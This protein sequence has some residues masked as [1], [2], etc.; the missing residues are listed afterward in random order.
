MAP[1]EGLAAAGP[2][3]PLPADGRRGARDRDA[4][5]RAGAARSPPPASS[6][7]V[8]VVVGT[9]GKA[10]GSYGAYV[11]ADAEMVEYLLNTA[12]SFIFS[13]A[14]PPPSVAAAQAGAGAARS[15]AGD[16]R[17]ARRQRRRPARGAGRRG[18]RRSGARRA[19]SSRSRSATPTQAMRALR[20]AARAR[21][22][23]PG[24]PA[25][26]RPRGHL[27]AALHGDGDPRPE[28]ELQRAARALG[29]ADARASAS[30]APRAGRSPRRLTGA[31]MRGVFVTG[32][33]TEVG[34][35]VVAAAI[36]R[37]LAAAGRAGR[38]L[39]A[40]RHRPRRPGRGRPRAAAPGRRARGRATR[41]SP[42]TAT[43]RR[44][45]PTSAAA[46]AGEEIDPARLRA[47]AAQAAAA[48]PT[49]SSARGSAACSCRS[50]RRLPG[51]RPRRRPRAAAGRSPPRPGSGRSTTRC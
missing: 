15:R 35:T 30:A 22:L 13:T 7:E 43:G 32:T 26:D 3:P 20:G 51:P 23:R 39:Q 46:L 42:P 6:G 29:A 25:A 49:R 24:D 10:L 19:R 28:A 36:A 44:P 18:P 11:C 21:R 2:Q 9:L 4:S 8:D 41:R 17:A 16:G 34:K 38:G 48:A 37:T 45:R 12:R 1:L 40:G 50:R 5:A 27:A 33:G 14:P 47:A 31:S